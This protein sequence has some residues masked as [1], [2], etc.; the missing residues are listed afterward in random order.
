[1]TRQPWFGCACCPP[2]IARLIASLGHYIY[3]KH[4][5]DLELYVHL[6]I[7]SKL[8]LDI[9]G[10]AVQLTQQT[11]YPWDGQVELELSLEQPSEF[12]LA[13]RIP[14]WCK[15]AKIFINGKETNV[16]NLEKG[17][18]KISR[19]WISGDR[20]EMSMEMPVEI[21]RS[22]PNVRENAGKVALQRGPVVFCLE[23]VDN[24]TNL[25]DIALLN[26]AAFDVHFDD[27]LLGGVTV[28]TGTGTRTDVNAYEQDELYTM[29]EYT[30]VSAPI[31]AIPY[32]AWSN[33]TP[34]EM[35][36]WIKNH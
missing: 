30:R 15:Q 8:E 23:E 34:G 24:G 11:N 10:K 26:D 21:I 29:H 12:T 32:F 33:R 35:T 9:D 17:Y 20:I 36:V 5:E 27:Q 18:A 19:T 6:Y 25:Q 16:A 4:Q 1:M 3:S 7:G 28:I 13:L 22:H 31:K 14:G 2:N